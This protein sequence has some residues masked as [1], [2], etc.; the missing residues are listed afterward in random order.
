[1]NLLSNQTNI[2]DIPYIY[3]YC[4][5]LTLM[6]MT[7]NEA[8][9]LFLLTDDFQENVQSLLSYRFENRLMLKKFLLLGYEG[10]RQVL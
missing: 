3:K 10:T 4:V 9:I 6:A 8:S 1:M 5:L 7:S 2:K